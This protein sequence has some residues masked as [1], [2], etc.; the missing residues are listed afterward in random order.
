MELNK[1]A[2]I[3]GLLRPYGYRISRGI[4]FFFFFFR[5]FVR[6]RNRPLILSNLFAFVAFFFSFFFYFQKDIQ[7]DT[8]A[9]APC[10]SC[11]LALKTSHRVSRARTLH[12]TID[13][14]HA[15]SYRDKS[16]TKVWHRRSIRNLYSTVFESTRRETIYLFIYLFVH[17]FLFSFFFQEIFTRCTRSLWSNS[18]IGRPV[19]SLRV[20]RYCIVND[21]W[22]TSVKKKKK[23][24]WIKKATGRENLVHD[25]ARIFVHAI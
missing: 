3:A 6:F 13:F 23:G 10:K 24:I 19:L 16:W 5:V 22:Q 9:H 21:V 4:G 25:R 17:I 15:N 12:Y 20:C 18:R 7:R 11:A 14:D 8:Y 1:R 2:L